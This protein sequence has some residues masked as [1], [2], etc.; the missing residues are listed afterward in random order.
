MSAPVAVRFA[1]TD[2]MG[3]VHHSSYIIWFE[4]GRVA[5]LETA[6]VPYSELADAGYNLAVTSIDATYRSACRFGD[7]IVVATHVHL[8]RSRQIGFRYEI[9]H[10]VRNTLLVSGRSGHVCVNSEG[11]IARVPEQFFN[12]LRHAMHEFSGNALAAVESDRDSCD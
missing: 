5:W 2:Q 6:G 10:A 9:R 8:L 7:S 1:E 11:R 4:I 12:R 3:V